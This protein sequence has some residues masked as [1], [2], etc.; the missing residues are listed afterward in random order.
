MTVNIVTQAS[1]IY[2]YWVLL[3]I[4]KKLNNLNFNNK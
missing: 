4:Y 3:V 2:I 1:A